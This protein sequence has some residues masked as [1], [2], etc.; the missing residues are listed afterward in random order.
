MVKSLARI[1]KNNWGYSV[2]NSLPIRF[3]ESIGVMCIA[4]WQ[5]TWHRSAGGVSVHKLFT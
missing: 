5:G 3:R 4:I 2:M 1:E